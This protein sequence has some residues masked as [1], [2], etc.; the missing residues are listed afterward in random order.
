MKNTELLEEK[1]AKE[2]EKTREITEEETMRW[3][4]WGRNQKRNGEWKIRSIHGDNSCWRRNPLGRRKDEGQ[5][6]K[7]KQWGMEN[8]RENHRKRKCKMKNNFPYTIGDELLEAKPVWDK[9][10]ETKQF[11]RKQRGREILR[12]NNRK[13]N[14]RR[15]HKLPRMMNVKEKSV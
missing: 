1:R 5:E 8:P 6:L 13:Q 7:R 11:K 9:K 2:A 15:V 4:N 10:D 3:K 12:E 14:S